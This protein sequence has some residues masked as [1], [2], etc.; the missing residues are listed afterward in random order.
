VRGF[1]GAQIRVQPVELGA[2]S[3]LVAARRDGEIP[4]LAADQ[5]AGVVDAT[6]P[7]GFG[8]AGAATDH[9]AERD[10][11]MLPRSSPVEAQR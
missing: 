10:G 3:S 9:A 8:S 2:Q 5:A 1:E 4:L 6:A 7:G 11:D